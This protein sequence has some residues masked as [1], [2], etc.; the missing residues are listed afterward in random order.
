MSE[1]R[2]FKSKVSYGVI[3]GLATLFTV[4]IT[5]F[6]VQKIWGAIIIPLGAATL[7]AYIFSNIWYAVDGN[8]LYIKAGIGS[9]TI[10]I[11]TIT[12]ITEVKSF[13]SGPALS[14]DRLEIFYNRYDSIQISPADKA[15][16]ITALKNINAEIIEPVK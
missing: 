5:I 7:I 11:Q 16:F 2:V 3:I 4:I 1:R 8:D 14:N 15:G 9:V 13:L 10:P 6:I 12:K